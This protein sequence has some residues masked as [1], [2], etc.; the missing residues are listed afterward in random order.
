LLVQELH[1]GQRDPSW[2]DAFDLFG[3]SGQ[4]TIEVGETAASNV[5]SG[6]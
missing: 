1:F 6:P 2:L 5:L 4:L 3:C